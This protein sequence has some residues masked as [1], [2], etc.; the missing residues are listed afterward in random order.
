MLEVWSFTLGVWSGVFD[1]TFLQ[2]INSYVLH[3]YCIK[4]LKRKITGIVHQGKPP[5]T[6]TV[7]VRWDHKTFVQVNI[8]PDEKLGLS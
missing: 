1:L 3:V 4:I 6:K 8:F 2:R 5:K 7:E